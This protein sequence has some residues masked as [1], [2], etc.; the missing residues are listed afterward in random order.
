MY[1]S[2]FPFPPYFPPGG[3]PTGKIVGG[4]LI[5]AWL[6]LRGCPKKFGNPR[7][8]VIEGSHPWINFPKDD[9]PLMALKFAEKKFPQF[10][11]FL[12]VPASPEI[13]TDAAQIAH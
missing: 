8:I 3:W 5:S 9:S 6:P 2:G 11:G 7:K 4:A 1:P 10:G 13:G 12:G